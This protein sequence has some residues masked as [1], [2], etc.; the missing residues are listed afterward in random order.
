VLSRIIGW[1]SAAVAGVV[2]ALAL[3]ITL[4][5]NHVYVST[6]SMYPTIPPGSLVFIKKEPSYRVGDVIEFWGNGLNFLHRIV[7]IDAN[8]AIITRGDNPQNAI[9]TFFPPTTATDVVG[10][11]VLAPRWIGFPELIVHTPGYGLSWLRAE[12]GSAGKLVVIAVTGAACF[13]LT[14]RAASRSTSPRHGPR[15]STIE[16]ARIHISDRPGAAEG[17]PD[18]L[19]TEVP[20]GHQRASPA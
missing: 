11:A 5:T 6:P 3:F 1:S 16:P 17:A 12:L 14:Q 13:L 4:F 2:A 10:K 18:S 19:S 8:G 20:T 9:D 15:Q 7:M